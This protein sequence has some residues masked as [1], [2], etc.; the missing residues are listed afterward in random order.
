MLSG[1]VYGLTLVTEIVKNGTSD[2]VI[3]QKQFLDNKKMNAAD[4]EAVIRP[5]ERTRDNSTFGKVR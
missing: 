3:C 2:T 5:T 4:D 1:R